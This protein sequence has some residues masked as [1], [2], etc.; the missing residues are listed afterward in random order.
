MKLTNFKKYLFSILVCIIC[1]FSYSNSNIVYADGHTHNDNCYSVIRHEHGSACYYDANAGGCGT[2]TIEWKAISTQTANCINCDGTYEYTY[3]KGTCSGCKKEYT[4]TIYGTCSKCGNIMRPLKEGNSIYPK[5]PST[6]CTYQIQGESLMLLSCDKETD[7]YYNSDGSLAMPECNKVAV[8]ISALKQLQS[9]KEVDTTI[10]VTFL[11]GH[12]EN[13][14]GTSNFNPNKSYNNNDVIIYYE[15][16]VF[17]AGNKGTLSTIIKMTTP[18]NLA[19]QTPTIPPTIIVTEVPP[20]STFVPTQHPTKVPTTNTNNGGNRLETNNSNSNT[21][22]NSNSSN[23]G[24]GSGNKFSGNNTTR[25][26]A[27]A[28]K[29]NNSNNTPTM[30]ITPTMTYKPREAIKIK[31]TRPLTEEEKQEKIDGS[32]VL[33]K[34]YR[35][36][37]NDVIGVQ[38]KKEDTSNHTNTNSLIT[39][40]VNKGNS[41]ETK[42]KIMI[43]VFFFAIFVVIIGIGGY[44]FIKK[45]REEDQEFSNQIDLQNSIRY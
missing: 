43:F 2:D 42:G 25:G 18:Y 9:G 33:T 32:M 12:K 17:K 45:K 38:K 41:Q 19:T 30:T 22:S 7:G 8:S 31:I 14:Q 44:M 16:I 27:V 3:Y 35:N 4:D 23:K 13:V 24:N 21:N 39:G 37:E 20:Q 5:Y 40:T 15:G 36:E 6:K 26:E 11:D 10:E 34:L 1:F 29:N 28:N